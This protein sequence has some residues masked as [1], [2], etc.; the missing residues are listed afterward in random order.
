MGAVIAWYNRQLLLAR[1][2]GD[3]QRL[4]ELTAQRQKPVEDQ[5]RL[6]DAGSEEIARIA[7]AYSEL[8]AELEASEPPAAE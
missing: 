5:A 2:S 8:L 7:G 3:Q 4:E 6:Q 1:R